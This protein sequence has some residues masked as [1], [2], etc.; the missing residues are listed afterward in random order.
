MSSG[1]KNVTPKSSLADNKAISSP[2]AVSVG[3]STLINSTASK[4]SKVH[5]SSTNS[6]AS[7]LSAI[8]A[9]S[10]KLLKQSSDSN[11]MGQGKVVSSPGTNMRQN[12][13]GNQRSVTQPVRP[14]SK[15]S[16]DSSAS[17]HVRFSLFNHCYQIPTFC[18]LHDFNSFYIHFFRVLK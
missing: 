15:Q 6:S 2:S 13:E 18:F 4:H 14:A 16:A 5:S 7:K 10:N 12:K 3:S 11:L 17:S 1:S 9:L 8:G